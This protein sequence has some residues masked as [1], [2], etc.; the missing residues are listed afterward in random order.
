MN[1]S[2]TKFLIVEDEILIA[3]QL[4][5]YLVNAGYTVCRIVGNGK[6]AVETARSECPG[7]IL[8]DINLQGAMDGIEAAR[9]IGEFSSPSVIFMTGYSDQALKDRAL[10]LHPAAYLYKPVDMRLLLTVI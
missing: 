2:Q 10:T 8:M 9:Q 4:E 6:D 5:R 3:L 1:P 7:V